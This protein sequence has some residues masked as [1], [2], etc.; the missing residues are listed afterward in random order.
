MRVL[1]RNER[2]SALSDARWLGGLN[3]CEEELTIAGR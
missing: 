3:P 1:D 2:R